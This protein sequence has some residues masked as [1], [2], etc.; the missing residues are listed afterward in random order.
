MFY[1]FSFVVSDKIIVN[2]S[3]YSPRNFYIAYSLTYPEVSGTRG[4][5]YSAPLLFGLT[6]VL[7]IRPR[8]RVGNWQP[9]MAPLPSA[10]RWGAGYS[11]PLL[12]SLTVVLDIRARV[13]VGQWWLP[14]PQQPTLT[15]D[16]FF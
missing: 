7:D 2:V 11:A 15:P 16:I 1:T 12:F 5:G 3:K 4:A 14:S 13:C 9:V 10:A 8:V 6:V